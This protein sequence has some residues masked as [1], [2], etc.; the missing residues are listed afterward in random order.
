MCRAS[1]VAAEVDSTQV[2]LL[3]QALELLQRGCVTGASNRNWASYGAEV[4]FA[5]GLPAHWQPLL[6]DPQTSGACWCRAPRKRWTRCWPVS[7]TQ[8]SSRRR[9][10]AAGRRAP[11]VSVR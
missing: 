9:G 2:P 5:D 11:G 4:R 3:P 1:G 10:G 7:T 8:G 6:T